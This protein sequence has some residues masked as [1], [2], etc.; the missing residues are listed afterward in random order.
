MGRVRVPGWA[1]QKTISENPHVIGRS[2]RVIGNG[3][4]P[5]I[6]WDPPLHMGRWAWEGAGAWLGTPKDHQRK[7]ARY[8]ARP[9]RVIRNCE[10][11]FIG[12][13]PPLHM[14]RWAWVGAGAWL[15][16]PKDHQ[17][18]PARYWALPGRVIVYGKA[19][20]ICRDPPLHQMRASFFGIDW[21]CPVR[22]RSNCAVLINFLW[23][24]NG[25]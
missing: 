3:E 17:R 18:K 20:V 9:G 2:G 10:A 11:P 25:C 21:L 24:L 1:S 15:G 6:G 14:G 13:D 23:S 7:P 19:P 22:T 12:W 4:A 16:T 5:F 8:W